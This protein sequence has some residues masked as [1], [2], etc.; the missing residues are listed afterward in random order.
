MANRK[1]SSGLKSRMKVPT[2]ID[3][4]YWEALEKLSAL[5]YNRPMSKII[6]EMAELI[7]IKYD[8]PVPIKKKDELKQENE[9]KD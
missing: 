7:L 9:Q 4:N 1:T 5:Q 2:T 6:D 3:I 8:Q